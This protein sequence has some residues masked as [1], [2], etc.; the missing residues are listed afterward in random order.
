MELIEDNSGANLCK[1]LEC[2]TVLIDQNPQ[3][4][5]KLYKLPDNATNM[6]YMDDDDGG[7]WACP[8]CETDENLIDL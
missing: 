4:G 7:W 6:Q 1:C 2:D 8:I 5:A 3:T